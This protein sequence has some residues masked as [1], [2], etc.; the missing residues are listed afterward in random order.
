MFITS[1][2]TLTNLDK[3]TPNC[4]IVTETPAFKDNSGSKLNSDVSKN[5]PNFSDSNTLPDTPESNKPAHEVPSVTYQR[6]AFCCNNYVRNEVSDTFYEDYLEF[7][8]YMSDTLLEKYPNTEFFLDLIFLY[9]DRIQENTDQNKVR[10]WTLF[11]Q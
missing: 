1:S 6:T 10:I 5:L 7:E 4:D 9:S 11:T 2:K 3:S 8:Y